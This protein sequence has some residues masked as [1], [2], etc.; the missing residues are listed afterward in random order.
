M[1][2][3]ALFDNNE[4]FREIAEN[5]DFDQIHIKMLNF[6]HNSQCFVIN[7][8]SS[9]AS[10]IRKE[11]GQ[12]ERTFKDRQMRFSLESLQNL[13]MALA[14]RYPDADIQSSR[15]FERVVM[16]DAHVQINEKNEAE[17]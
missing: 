16:V 8:K 12:V 11:D 4:S 6:E 3:D 10:N 14:E 9:L 5:A 2:C 13:L 17:I 1:N 15:N 7:I